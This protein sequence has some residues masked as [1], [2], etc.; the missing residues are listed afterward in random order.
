MIWLGPCAPPTSMARSMP[1]RAGSVEHAAW[2]GKPKPYAAGYASNVSPP[3]IGAVL[4][5]YAG[6]LTPRCG[7]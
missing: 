4:L 6:Q 2:T 7:L 1:A 3:Q 5:C